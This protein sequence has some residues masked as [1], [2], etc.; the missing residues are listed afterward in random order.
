MTS[1]RT[2]GVEVEEQEGG[3]LDMMDLNIAMT[4]TKNAADTSKYGKMTTG[5]ET[6]RGTMTAMTA[7]TKSMKIKGAGQK[8]RTVQILEV[9]REIL[10]EVTAAMPVEKMRGD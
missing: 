8:T 7:V 6:G 3:Q 1:R 9:M 10:G 2:D 5:D 4:D